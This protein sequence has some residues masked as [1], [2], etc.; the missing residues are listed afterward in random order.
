VAVKDSVFEET[1]G[2]ATLKIQ[3]ALARH[4]AMRNDGGMVN[5][6]RASKHHRAVLQPWM[7][8]YS[9]AFLSGARRY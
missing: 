2:Y 1:E 3:V 9:G 8:R 6:C 7:G 4:V 5:I